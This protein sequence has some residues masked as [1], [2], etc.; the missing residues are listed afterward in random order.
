MNFLKV[1]HGAN[2]VVVPVEESDSNNYQLLVVAGVGAVLLLH[3]GSHDADGRDE[4]RTARHNVKSCAGGGA[5]ARMPL[6]DGV[7]FSRVHALST[8]ELH[9][10]MR[11]SQSHT[12]PGTHQPT[13]ATAP[14]PRLHPQSRQ[15]RVV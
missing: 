7:C 15:R 1:H 11:A 2:D 13:P 10:H 14:T 8:A 4:R 5:L 6:A 12:S 3:Y 9:T